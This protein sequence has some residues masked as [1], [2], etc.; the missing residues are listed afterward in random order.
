M[1]NAA[2]CVRGW[3]R[4]KPNPGFRPDYS[5]G[6]AAG[7][8]AVWL[9]NGASGNVFEYVHGHTGN[10]NG[11]ISGVPGAFAGPAY[12]FS[13]GSSSYLEMNS[14]AAGLPTGDR[15]VLIWFKL[16]SILSGNRSITCAPVD[17]GGTD[18]PNYI[19]ASNQAG[20]TL[21]WGI[22]G[23]P[24][25]TGEAQISGNVSSLVG[26]WHQAVVTL[27]GNTVTGYL[28]G[29]PIT[30]TTRSSSTVTV[31]RVYIA[32]YNANFAQ[33]SNVTVDH[34]LI[35]SRALKA[36]E[37][38][39]LYTRPF[40][41]MTQ[42]APRRSTIYAVPAPP[43]TWQPLNP[44]P[45][46]PDLAEEEP[47]PRRPLSAAFL[48]SGTPLSGG[49]LPFRARPELPALEAP[50]LPGR[51]D[52]RDRQFPTALHPGFKVSKALVTLVPWSRDTDVVSR[53][54]Q[55]AISEIVNALQV[56]GELARVGNAD[57]TLAYRSS[58]VNN[59]ANL[60][61]P[62]T[63]TDALERIAACLAKLGRLP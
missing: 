12:N 11:S 24:G 6:L 50:L 56:A 31:G 52:S 34:Q 48:T 27:A 22:D 62:T 20:N 57:W 43:A 7:L 2:A 41:F 21:T 10:L 17:D 46:A 3:G 9:F 37:V 23:A 26:S 29:L 47:W 53:R 55:Q 59:W 35:W 44:R 63:I 1:P 28:D 42:P 58:N 60:N 13:N 61:P 8:Y 33:Y 5:S 32:R 15:T 38:W 16:Q 45:A 4:R 51:T 36:D 40:D 14:A 18:T 54:H 39:Q 19:L 49:W 30:T 25:Y